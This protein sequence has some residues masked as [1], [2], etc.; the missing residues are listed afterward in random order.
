M[1]RLLHL[2]RSSLLSSNERGM[3][4]S[5]KNKEGVGGLDRKEESGGEGE[6]L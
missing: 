4:W 1:I 6:R 2:M 3:D 5:M